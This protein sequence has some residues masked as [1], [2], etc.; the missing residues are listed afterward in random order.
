MSVHT[1]VEQHVVEVSVTGPTTNTTMASADARS[2]RTHCARRTRA[3]DAARVV[4]QEGPA[5]Q[6]VSREYRRHS[7]N[8]KYMVLSSVK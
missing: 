3:G 2:V 7:L 6:E 4:L 5:Q 8:V 1:F